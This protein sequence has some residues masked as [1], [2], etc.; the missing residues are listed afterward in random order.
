MWERHR[1][2]DTERIT[3]ESVRR[4][5]LN[6]TAIPLRVACLITKEKVRVRV[7][8]GKGMNGREMGVE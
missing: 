7:R 6:R 1:V 5:P 4:D 2:V 8:G 3:E